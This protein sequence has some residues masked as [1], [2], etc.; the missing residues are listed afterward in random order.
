M[1]TLSSTCSWWQQQPVVVLIMEQQQLLQKINSHSSW[2][3]AKSSS[4]AKEFCVF[5][6][7]ALLSLCVWRAPL[8]AALVCYVH[9]CIFAKSKE[10]QP[11]LPLERQV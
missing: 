10:T 1:T 3:L 8:R 2:Q 9:V 5:G 11:V 4:L 7:S 6:M